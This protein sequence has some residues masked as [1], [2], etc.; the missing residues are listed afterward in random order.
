MHEVRQQNSPYM[1][2]WSRLADILFQTQ[3]A[4][5]RAAAEMHA[6]SLLGRASA[7]GDRLAGIDNGVRREFLQRS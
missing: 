6:S 7:C 3:T 4:A 2:R 1:A 5:L